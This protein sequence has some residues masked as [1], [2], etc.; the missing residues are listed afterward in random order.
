MPT[1]KPLTMLGYLTVK[2]GRVDEFIRRNTENGKATRV[3]DEGCITY[4]LYQLAD[5]DR[6]FVLYE[7]WRDEA[8]LNAHIARMQRAYGVPPPGEVLPAAFLD[9]LD[10]V[11]ASSLTEVA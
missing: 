7:Q 8:S 3:E 1:N 6:K 11:N 5:E 4:I 2:E 10:G 9:L